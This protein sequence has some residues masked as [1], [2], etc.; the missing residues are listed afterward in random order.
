M[1]LNTM[2]TTLSWHACP[3]EKN[4]MG[5][6]RYHGTPWDMRL[7]VRL[8]LLHFFHFVDTQRTVGAT[9]KLIAPSVVASSH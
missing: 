1:G 3:Q 6:V 4:P 7:L 9:Q 2:I 8:G 5:D